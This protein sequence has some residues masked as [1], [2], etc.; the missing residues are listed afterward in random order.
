MK[1]IGFI[2]YYIDEWHANNYPEF[3]RK[4]SRGGE[5]EV[6]LAWEECTPEGKRSLEQWC[7][8][9]KVGKAGSMEEVIEQ[10]DCLIV[11]SPDN[12]ERHEDLADLPL[13]SGKPVYV[14]KTFAPTRAAAERMFAKAEKH[15]TP[16]MSSSALRYGSALQKAVKE[17]LAGKGVHFVSTLGPGSF[18]NYSVHQLEMLVMALGVGAQRVMQCGNEYAGLLLIDYADGRR[19]LVQQIPD[20]PFRISCQHGL[21][22]GLIIDQ[23]DDFFPGLMEA[24]LEFFLTGLSPISP[25]ETIEIMALY[26]AG[27]NALKAPDRWEDVPQGKL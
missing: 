2:D 20:Q 24:I 12:A 4:T 15:G 9:L 17:T 19:G 1:K 14:D 27:V 26:E 22:G 21:S 25:E 11:L 16:L 5:F 18:G 13:R 3:F 10:C 8:E 23:M 7:R 6:A